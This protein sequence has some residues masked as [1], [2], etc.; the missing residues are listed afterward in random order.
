MKS[1]SPDDFK[2][3]SRLKF[4]S[5]ETNQMRKKSSKTEYCLNILFSVSSG[6]QYSTKLVPACLKVEK[7]RE[8]EENKPLKIKKIF[9][10]IDKISFF[11]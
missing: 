7:E 8:K 9:S 6:I 2:L 5:M 4:S 11:S 1:S 3:P 10:S